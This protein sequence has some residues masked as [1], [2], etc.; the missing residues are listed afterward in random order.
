[1]GFLVSNNSLTMNCIRIT[2][3]LVGITLENESAL[4]KFGKIWNLIEPE[5]MG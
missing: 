3:D 2:K 4:Q 5:L 1:M